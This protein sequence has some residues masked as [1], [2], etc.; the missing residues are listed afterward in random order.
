LVMSTAAWLLRGGPNG[1]ASAAGPGILAATAGCGRAPTLTNGTHTIQSGGQNRSYI[2]RIPDNYDRNRPYRL[3]FAFHWLNGT[4]NDVATGGADG[5]A[6]A[7]YGLQ[8]R[9][10]NSTIFVAPQGI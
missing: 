10:N 2:L 4:A 5:A 8:P 1:T 6:F 9:S 3:V 7:Y